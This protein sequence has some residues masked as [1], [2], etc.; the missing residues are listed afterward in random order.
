[1]PAGTNDVFI[2]RADE[3]CPGS[4]SARTTKKRRG[5]GCKPRRC[6]KTARSLRSAPICDR[7]LRGI[8]PLTSTERYTQCESIAYIRAVCSPRKKSLLHSSRSDASV[9]SNCCAIFV[10]DMCA[11]KAAPLLLHAHPLLLSRSFGVLDFV[12]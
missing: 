3:T 7:G 4:Q 2:R 12:K 1:M 8:C 9:R 5:T 6:G 11:A 10:R